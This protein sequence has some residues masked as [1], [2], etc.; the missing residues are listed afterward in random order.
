MSFPFQSSKANAGSGFLLFHRC[1]VAYVWHK[2]KGK[3]K[4]NEQKHPSPTPTPI[5]CSCSSRQL[6]CVH[7][8]DLALVATQYQCEVTM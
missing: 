4:Q 8:D 1:L 6:S 5:S 7:N 2:A 3:N